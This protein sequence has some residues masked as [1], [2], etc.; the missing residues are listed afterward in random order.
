MTSCSRCAAYCSAGEAGVADQ[1]AVPQRMQV[2][3][4]VLQGSVLASEQGVGVALEVLGQEPDRARCL[5]ELAQRIVR[6]SDQRRV[7]GDVVL[8]HGRDG[9]ELLERTVQGLQRAARVG[10]NRSDLALEVLESTVQG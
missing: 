2:A 8:D 1:A 9:V 3:T 6:L 4:S 10:H 5:L 7:P